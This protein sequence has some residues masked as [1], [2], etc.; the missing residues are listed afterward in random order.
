MPRRDEKEHQP[1][2]GRRKALEVSL[3]IRAGPEVLAV[4]S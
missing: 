1:G 4:T 3:R 2:L